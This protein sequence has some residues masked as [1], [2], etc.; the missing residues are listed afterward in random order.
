M[1]LPH[2]CLGNVFG[3]IIRGMEAEKL[4]QTCKKFEKAPGDT[5][6]VGCLDE[7]ASYSE[8]QLADER[9]YEMGQRYE[10]TGDY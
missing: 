10:R 9:D 2:D 8:Q 6:C 4:C 7:Q 1:E 5:E 3:E